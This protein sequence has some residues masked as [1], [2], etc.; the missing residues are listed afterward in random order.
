MRSLGVAPNQTVADQPAVTL[1]PLTLT[2]RYLG[3]PGST[4]GRRRFRVDVRLRD[5]QQR[6]H[7]ARR[8][9]AALDQAVD[10]LPADAE[11]L[12]DLGGG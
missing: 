2:S 5:A 3:L 9:L 1:S 7:V 8:Q 10:G 11:L 12:R 6:A 4:C